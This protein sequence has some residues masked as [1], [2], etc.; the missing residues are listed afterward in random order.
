MRTTITLDDELFAEAAAIAE[1]ENASSLLTKAL[2]MM[3]A[4]ES[5]KRLLRLSGGTPEFSIP[6]RDSR[7]V[8]FDIGMVAENEVPYKK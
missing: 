4:T 7:G 6:G 2:K 3:I 1:D 5:K 8:D